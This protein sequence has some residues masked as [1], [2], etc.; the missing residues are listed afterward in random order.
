MDKTVLFRDFKEEDVDFIYKCKN[1]EKLNSL[2][3]GQYHPLSYEEAVKW[4][5][6]CMG[7]HTEYK[8]WAIC[9]NDSERRIIGWVSLSEINLSDKTVVFHGIVI[10]DQMYRNGFAWIEAYLFIYEYVFEQLKF[11]SLYGSALVDQISTLTIR[12]VMF[13]HVV[14]VNKDAVCRDGKYYDVSTSVLTSSD[15]FS[16]KVNGDYELPAILK[17]MRQVTKKNKLKK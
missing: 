4:V 1:D 15:Y 3:V 16:H 6:G 11:E 13:H 2:I 10:G 7:N 12:E 5:H 14:S 17:R 9:T 8:Y